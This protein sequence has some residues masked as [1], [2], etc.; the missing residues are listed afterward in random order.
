M[1]SQEAA[2]NLAYFRGAGD[3]IGS[4]FGGTA[5]QALSA[6]IPAPDWLSKLLLPIA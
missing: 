6:G 3:R 5:S 4:A 2:A 1:A